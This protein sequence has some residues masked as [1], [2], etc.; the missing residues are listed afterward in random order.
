MTAIVSVIYPQGAKFDMD[1][2]LKTHMPLVQSNWGPLGLKSYK[3]AHYSSEG[4]YCVQAWLE[5]ESS[6]HYTKASSSDAAKIV[7]ADIPNF[8]DKQPDLIQGTLADSKAF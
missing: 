7:L 4:P 5:W 8:T 2:Y 3:I 6:E 1:Y